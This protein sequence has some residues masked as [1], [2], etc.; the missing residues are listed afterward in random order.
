MPNSDMQKTMQQSV[1]DRWKDAADAEKFAKRYKPNPYV[2]SSPELKKKIK[3]AKQVEKAPDEPKRLRKKSGG[4][5][6]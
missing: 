2:C 6:L 1:K 4:V 5:Q 3:P